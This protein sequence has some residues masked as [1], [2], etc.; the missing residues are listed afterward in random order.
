MTFLDASSPA[1]T[2]GLEPAVEDVE[3][4]TGELVGIGFEQEALDRNYWGIRRRRH[5]QRKFT[6][7]GDISEALYGDRRAWEGTT[8]EG[9]PDVDAQVEKLFADLDA[10]RGVDPGKLA[11][12]PQ[13]FADLD[14]QTLESLRTEMQEERRDVEERAN[15]RSSPS[16]AGGVA[17]FVGQAGAAITDIEGLVTLP[18]GAGAGSLG[19]TVLIEGALGA[20]SE[21]L[22]IP[23]YNAQAK[24]LDTDAP[25]PLQLLLF[26]A[27]FGAALPIAGRTMRQGAQ[28][29]RKGA[30]VTNRQLL[31]A[32]KKIAGSDKVRGAATAL[33]RE[34]A[35]LDSAPAGIPPDQHAADLDATEIALESGDPVVVRPE[36]IDAGSDG[37]PIAQRLMADLQTELGITPEQA[38]GIVGNLAHESGGFRSLQEIAPLVPGSR[39][40]FGYAQWTG[41]RRVA[42]ENWA[43]DQGLDPRS[44]QANLGFLLHELR[45]TPE[46]AVLDR[47]RT[48]ESAAD[49]AQIFSDQFLRPGIPHMDSRLKWTARALGGDIGTVQGPLRNREGVL[50]ASFDGANLKADD[51]GFEITAGEITF[52]QD[53]ARPADSISP[54]ASARVADDIVTEQAANAVEADLR[55]RA[56]VAAAEAD[57]ILINAR[58]DA[59]KSELDSVDQPAEQARLREEIAEQ[60]TALAPVEQRLEGTR[61]GSDAGPGREPS[62]SPAQEAAPESWVFVDRATSKPVLET[63][64]RAKL[65]ALNQDRYA[66]VPARQYLEEFNQRVA[67]TGGVDPEPA[68]WTGPEVAVPTNQPPAGYASPQP[69]LFDDPVNSTGSVAQIELLDADLRARLEANPDLNIEVP[70]GVDDGSRNVT[71]AEIL[72]DHDEEADFLDQLKIC[73]PKGVS[74]G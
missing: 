74:N 56:E 53:W 15:N 71:L 25:D 57:R 11:N 2:A 46:G 39:G 45:N 17:E 18:F 50:R 63:S 1:A 40:G 55:Q 35:A 14:A 36:D 3:T 67:R 26:G 30:E 13:N 61:E 8:V 22:A 66:A 59:L 12:F 49:A 29:T 65:E 68:P 19:R 6:V 16:F 4:S 70:T 47:L 44:Y 72:T 24:F 41:P 5:E 60:E 32:A 54:D 21:A 58:I 28:L 52:R 34:E 38:A 42:F 31:A 48:A 64:D 43:Q 73:M 62:G 23:A 37:Q 33:A 69:E 51:A 27:T 9:I 10:R 7:M 20:G